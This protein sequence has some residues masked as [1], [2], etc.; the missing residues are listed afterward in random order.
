MDLTVGQSLSAR[1]EGASVVS[2]QVG[3]IRTTSVSVKSIKP[4]ETLLVN[5]SKAF[6]AGVSCSRC[7]GVGKVPLLFVI[8]HVAR[9]TVQGEGHGCERLG[10]PAPPPYRHSA[11]GKRPGPAP[12]HPE[13]RAHESAHCVLSC[14]TRHAA[15][16]GLVLLAFV[17]TL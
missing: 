7:L 15:T 2:A 1:G 11:A 14:H 8:S 4:N 12:L 17:L 13:F 10:D 3:L 6:A 5:S 9:D 16:C